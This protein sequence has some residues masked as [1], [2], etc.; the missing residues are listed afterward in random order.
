MQ[1]RLLGFANEF[2]AT[3]V[4]LFAYVGGIVVLAV[5]GVKVFGAPI[6]E[7]AVDPSPGAQWVD[8]ERPFHSFAA[9]APNFA[10]PE[11]D[12][13]IRRNTRGGGRKDIMSWG[14]A[15]DDAAT[16]GSRLMIELYRPGKEIAHFGDAAGAVAAL[17]ADFGGPY[18]LTPAEPIDSKF[19]RLASFS[20]T[21][22]S[23]GQARGCLGFAHAFS[24]PLLQIS[25]WYCKGDA[26]VVEPGTLTCALDRLSLMMAGSEPKITALF[27]RAE[28]R[29]KVCGVKS[30]R[31]QRASNTRR[32]DW[33]DARKAPRLRGR[34]A[35]R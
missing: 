16:V 12:Y 10:E 2:S 18:T 3:C 6:V 21:A 28:L 17:M 1:S 31:M 27:A 15:W 13:A 19:G 23:S 5:V 4:R 26:E 20:F 8:V 25:G 34:F 7:A 35:T 9:S 11:P 29:R 32:H 24:E 33:I 22:H 14:P 30:P